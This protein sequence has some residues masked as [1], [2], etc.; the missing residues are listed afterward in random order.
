AGAGNK[1]LI[2]TYMKILDPGSTVREGEY[3]TTQKGGKIP[4]RITAVY[5]RVVKGEKLAP[6]VRAQF[7]EE[8]S[9]IYRQSEA[10]HEKIRNI[11]RGIASRSN[12]DP[13]NVVVDYSPGIV[14]PKPAAPKKATAQTGPAPT[15]PLR[16][17]LKL[18]PGTIDNGYRFKGGDP[19]VKG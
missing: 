18:E 12:L 4:E 1:R 15:V 16:D 19:A 10:D 6:N 5:N 2:F 9:K 8:A 3:A 7:V 13:D 11:Y 17:V 14:P